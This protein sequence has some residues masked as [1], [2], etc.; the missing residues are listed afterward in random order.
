LDPH[1]DPTAVGDTITFNV[2]DFLLSIDSSGSQTPGIATS[3][4]ETGEK[5]WQIQIRQN[6]KFHDGRTLT[7]SDVVASINRVRLHPRSENRNLFNTVLRTAALGPMTV[8]IELS[9]PDAVFLKKLSGVAI[10]PVDV[11]DEIVNP[12]GTGPYRV[13]GTT[14][15]QGVHLEAFTEYWGDKSTEQSVELLFVQNRDQSIDLLLSGQVDIVTNL[16]SESVA[17]IEANDQLWVESSLGSR[18]Y[19]LALNANRAPF[20]DDILREAMEYAL[21]RKL[22]AEEVF[23]NYAR[24]AGQLVNETAYGHAPDLTPVNPAPSRARA[25]VSGTIQDIPLDFDLEC[26]A[27]NERLAAAVKE[28]L[29]IAG[30]TAR[31]QPRPWGEVLKRLLAGDSQAVVFTWRSDLIDIGFTFDQLI[32]AGSPKNPKI[33]TSNESIERLVIASRSMQDPDARLQLLHSI[34]ERVARHRVIV[35]LVWVMDLYGVRRDLDWKPLPSGI[36]DLSSISRRP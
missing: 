1:L 14:P 34:T 36:I 17:R 3:W 12:V 11:P 9:A 26:A 27:G 16:R 32:V 24:P 28:Q 22:L 31:V 2:Y 25:L 21:D 20:E 30:V 15:D 33:G 23:L 7:A 8:E 10:V 4:E 18:V 5:N 6:V 35:P 13:V 29:E 19:F